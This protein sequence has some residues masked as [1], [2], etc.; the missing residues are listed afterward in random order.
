M[1]ITLRPMPLAPSFKS[2]D[3]G[4]TQQARR[5]YPAHHQERG[6]R[7]VQNRAAPRQRRRTECEHGYY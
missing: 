2:H 7:V 3:F 6:A 5:S 1:P 4:E